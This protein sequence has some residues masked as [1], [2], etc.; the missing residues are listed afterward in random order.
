MKA[1]LANMLRGKERKKRKKEQICKVKQRQ[2]KKVYIK[3]NCKGKITVGK[4]NNGI[5][6]EKYNRFLKIKSIKKEKRKKWKKKEKRKKRENST[7][8][9]K[10]NVDAEVYNNKMFD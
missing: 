7:E 1:N 4:A 3:I 8:L 10:P 5:N 2:K 9:Q 6:V